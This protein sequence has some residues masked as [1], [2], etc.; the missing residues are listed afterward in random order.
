MRLNL[1]SALESLETATASTAQVR[2]RLKTVLEARAAAVE[3]GADKSNLPAWQQAER[4]LTEMAGSIES[5]RDAEVDGLRELMAQQF[6]TARRDALRDKLLSVAKSEILA[7]ESAG[8]DQQFPTLMAR[9]RQAMSRAETQLAQESLE[10]SRK[11]ADEAAFHA[12]HASGQM[13]YIAATRQERSPDEALLLP[14]D[15]LL[16]LMAAAWGDSIE[17]GQGG[18]AAGENFKRIYQRGLAQDVAERDSIERAAKIAHTSMEQTLSEMQTRFADVQNQII[19]HEQRVL[20]I[21]AERDIAVSRLRKNEL[22]AQRVQLAQTAFDP[23]DAVV[24]QT[25]EGH[26]VIHLYGLKFS[27]GQATLGKDQRSILTKAAEAIAVFPDIKVVVEGHTDDEGSEDSNLELSE[28]RAAA[29]GEALSKELPESTA[30]TTVGKGESSPI[31]S[32]KSARG[33]AL[34]RRID[35]VLLP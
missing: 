3:V 12:R 25:M 34:N 11:A 16:E 24:Y 20:D 4:G 17:F 23:G 28:Q 10:E 8:C 1:E 32:N 18:A 30:L 21:Q 13:K 26:V 15:D 7:A 6:W 5:G 27:S 2:E 22:T 31:A 35:L 9:A 29:V 33:K 19:E 14:Y